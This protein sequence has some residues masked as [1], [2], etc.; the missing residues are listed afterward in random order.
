MTTQKNTTK[1]QSLAIGGILIAY[2]ALFAGVALVF[3]I[4]AASAQTV[5]ADVRFNAVQFSRSGDLTVKLDIQLNNT[6]SWVQGDAYAV[7]EVVEAD[8]SC[9]QYGGTPRWLMGDED[10]RYTKTFGGDEYD[11]VNDNRGKRFCLRVEDARYGGDAG[12]IIPSISDAPQTP[13]NPRTPQNP[14]QPSLQRPTIA[15]KTGQSLTP[16]F[17]VTV[18][19]GNASGTV[20]LFGSGGC[21]GTSIGSENVSSTTVDVTTSP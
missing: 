17:T 8:Q 4:Q 7:W 9:D 10:G 12:V 18:D 5:R 6:A 15:L 20:E 13:Q 3:G 21:F 2:A 19:S 16:T 14:G 11:I 1:I